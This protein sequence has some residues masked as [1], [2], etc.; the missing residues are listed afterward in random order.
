[1]ESKASMW[2]RLA[3]VVPCHRKASRCFHV[4][5]KPMPICA[6]CL[7]ILVGYLWLPVFLLLPFPVPWWLGFLLQIP[8]LIDG[9]TQL[10]KFRESTNTLRCVTGLLSG[11][12]MSILATHFISLLLE[13]IL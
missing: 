5:G 3:Y 8:T 1:M 13:D 7:S 9:V 10:V 6:R 11:I 12:G 2:T 4:N